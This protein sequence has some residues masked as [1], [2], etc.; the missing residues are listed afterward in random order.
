MSHSDQIVSR[1]RV[2]DHGEVYTAPREVNAMLDLVKQETERVESRFLE[3]AC[4]T[5]NFLEEI[6]RRK[7]TVVT[8][9][10]AA[11]PEEKRFNAFVAV[12]SLYG[13]DI[14]A[15]NVAACR[16]RLLG[17]VLEECSARRCEDAKFVA[18]LQ[19]VLSKNIIH[20][21]ALTLQT[22]G[23]PPGPIIFSEWS[24]LAAFKVQ[25]RDFRFDSLTC[26][27]LPLFSDNGENVLFPKP[28]KDDYKPVNFLE[29]EGN[30]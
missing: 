19:F 3:P 29:V 11:S 28:M 30:D 22:C 15:D 5:G 18:A 20:G 9:R 14:L 2:A 16:E 6:L 4:G 27:D 23:D 7:L 1:R 25:R 17:I 13:I 12:S 24:P 8:A 21:D 26:R 10:Y